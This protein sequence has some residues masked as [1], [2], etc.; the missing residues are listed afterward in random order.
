MDNYMNFCS[1]DFGFSK[2]FKLSN[3]FNSRWFSS[4]LKNST[5]KVKD[6]PIKLK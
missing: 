6:N 3:S 1:I 4:D 2:S 5:S